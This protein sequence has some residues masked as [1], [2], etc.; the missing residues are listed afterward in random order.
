MQIRLKLILP[1]TLE[2]L[3]K[4]KPGEIA[5]AIEK[6]VVRTLCRDVRVAARIAYEGEDYDGD[7][8]DNDNTDNI[9]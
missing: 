8:I 6:A 2:A 7:P 4:S 1:D 9:D 5:A 3:A